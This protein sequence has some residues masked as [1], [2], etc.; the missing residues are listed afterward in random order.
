[1]NTS[2]TDLR[3]CI[4]AVVFYIVT[5]M[6]LYLHRQCDEIVMSTY[7]YGYATAAAL[8][9]TCMFLILGVFLA[10]FALKARTAGAAWI[11]ELVVILLP[12]VLMLLSEF[13]FA[14]NSYMLP[15]PMFM[16]C[17]RGQLP[18]IGGAV[19]GCYA[20]SEIRGRMKK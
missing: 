18:A 2:K 3:G 9:T 20:F 19:I 10:Y 16:K 13:E 1:M 11:I 15:L 17:Y 12:A 8:I 7:N 4:A 14:Q 6:G 5:A